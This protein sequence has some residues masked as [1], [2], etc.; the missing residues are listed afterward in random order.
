[1]PKRMNSGLSAYSSN[2]TS[3][4]YNT[5]DF[6]LRK[7]CFHLPSPDFILFCWWSYWFYLPL[8]P[9]LIFPLVP[10]LPSTKPS[11]HSCIHVLSFSGHALY[12]LDTA[13]LASAA[14]L[15]IVSHWPSSFWAHMSC[16]L[17]YLQSSFLEESCLPATIGLASLL[18]PSGREKMF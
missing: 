1:M 13:S 10:S 12:G 16:F 15:S 11:I 5:S 2:A 14:A 18:T 7:N 17:T 9:P 6:L 4:K 3:S 8:S